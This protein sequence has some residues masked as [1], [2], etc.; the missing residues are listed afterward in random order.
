MPPLGDNSPPCVASSPAVTKTTVYFAPILTLAAVL[1]GCSADPEPTDPTAAPTTTT[2]PAAA[3]DEI[4]ADTTGRVTY[5]T[6]AA[7]VTTAVRGVDVDTASTEY[8]NA[9]R[10]AYFWV[11]GG[12]G[13][14]AENAE[15]F[16]ALLQSDPAEYGLETDGPLWEE[17]NAEQHAAVIAAINDAANGDC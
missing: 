11:A 5:E 6:S 14:P 7:G 17:Q 2:A 15:G 4:P 12:D 9:C 13:T 1:V 3:A 16:L 8:R 10:D